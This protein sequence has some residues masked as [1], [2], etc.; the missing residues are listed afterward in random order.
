VPTQTKTTKAGKANFRRN[1]DA[2]PVYKHLCQFCPQRANSAADAK[3][4]Q[5]GQH[6]HTLVAE[7]LYDCCGRAGIVIVS[8]HDRVC[9]MV[10]A[11]RTRCARHSTVHTNV[12]GWKKPGLYAIAAAVVGAVAT[13]VSTWELEKRRDVERRGGQTLPAG[14]VIV[15]ANHTSLADGVFLALVGQR[16]G[17]PLRLL[18]TAGIIEAPLLGRLF[19]KLGFIAV[20]RKSTNPAA[21]LEHAAAALIAGDAIA[22]YPEGRIT[23]N[24]KGWPERAKTGAVRLAL[25]TGAPIV[26]VA[27][28][29]IENVIGRKKHQIVVQL[30]TNVVRRPKVRIQVG[31]PIDVRKLIGL[32]PTIE[33]TPDEVRLA[34]DEVTRRLIAMLETMR[35]ETAP[36]P[37]GVERVDE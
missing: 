6:W 11:H 30:V 22:L 14:G 5:V 34:A 23:R 2:T 15:I 18:G 27:S 19:K 33:P 37:I 12:S 13:S 17:R 31:D 9:K 4:A 21:A 3:L 7:L 10:L 16:L 1:I 32:G 36:N 26:P 29:G 25:L 24:A 20:H 35:S 28:V 8:S